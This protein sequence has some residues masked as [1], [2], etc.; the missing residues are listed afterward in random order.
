M[1]HQC[2]CPQDGRD[3]RGRCLGFC[4]ECGDHILSTGR[5]TAYCPSCSV[6]PTCGCPDADGFQHFEGCTETEGEIEQ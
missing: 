4:R 1:A 2:A 5:Y 3:C 6:C